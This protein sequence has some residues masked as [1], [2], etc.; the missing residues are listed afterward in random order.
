MGGGEAEPVGKNEPSL[1]E[2]RAKMKNQGGK[3]QKTG[4]RL[5]GETARGQ[6]LGRGKLADRQTGQVG[7]G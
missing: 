6:Q 5:K 2:G 7:V 3:R 4:G 1:K